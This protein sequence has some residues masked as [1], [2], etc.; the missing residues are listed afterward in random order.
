[1]LFRSIRM[2]KVY[3]SLKDGMSKREDYFDLGIK[4]ETSEVKDVFDQPEPDKKGDGK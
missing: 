4:K 3:R 2:K 1:M